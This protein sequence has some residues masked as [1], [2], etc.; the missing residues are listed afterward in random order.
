MRDL[1]GAPLVEIVSPC[2]MMT[3]LVERGVR[4]E[5]AYASDTP[6]GLSAGSHLRSTAGGLNQG[7]GEFAE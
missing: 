5:E 3:W 2:Y 6:G 4:L 1:A 7:R